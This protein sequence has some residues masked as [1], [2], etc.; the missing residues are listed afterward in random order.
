MGVEGVTTAEA[1]T[2]SWKTWK[3][4][5]SFKKVQTPPIF[6]LRFLKN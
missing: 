5:T 2:W 1:G 6:L 4:K 3:M